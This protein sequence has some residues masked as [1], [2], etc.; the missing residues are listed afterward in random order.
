LAFAPLVA[1][2]M[3]IKHDQISGLLGDLSCATVERGANERMDH[4]DQR[5]GSSN[6]VELVKHVRCEGVKGVL[7]ES[8]SARQAARTFSLMVAP[9]LRPRLVAYVMMVPGP[10]ENIQCL[11]WH[12]QTACS[13][14][15]FGVYERDQHVIDMVANGR[16][17][18]GDRH[19]IEPSILSTSSASSERTPSG[20]RSLP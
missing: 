19:A 1:T 16:K 3:M 5:G 13:I 2:M 10:H 11:V 9:P 20:V 15:G 17:R 4:L 8:R 7:K 18:L 6:R 12:H 14:D